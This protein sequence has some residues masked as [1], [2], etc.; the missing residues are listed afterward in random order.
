MTKPRISSP[1]RLPTG[2][3]N[4]GRNLRAARKRL[5]MNQEDLAK[6]CGVTKGLIS[7]FEKGDTMPSVPV[8]MKL[9]EQ[10]KCGV[11]ALLFGNHAFRQATLPGMGLDD[12]VAK[13]PDAMREFVLLSLARA[14]N[15]VGHVPAQFLSAPTSESWPQFAAYLAA[16]SMVEQPRKEDDP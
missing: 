6:K 7:Q 9:G 12:R 10:L 15:A 1:A 8:L 5:E 14:E 16:I 2:D 3:P 13:L 4:F 11:D